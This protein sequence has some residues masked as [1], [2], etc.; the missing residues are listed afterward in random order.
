MGGC[1]I[2]LLRCSPS[3]SPQ[4]GTNLFIGCGDKVLAVPPYQLKSQSSFLTDQ[5]GEYGQ[6]W[7]DIFIALLKDD[8]MP[9]FSQSEITKSGSQS[10][11]GIPLRSW[12]V[13]TCPNSTLAAQMVAPSLPPLDPKEAL[14]P[15]Q[16]LFLGPLFTTIHYC[17]HIVYH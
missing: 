10:A 14:E 1:E 8:L 11:G 7:P 9:Q 15:P 17:L 6:T 4:G 13:P 2:H 3:G 12:K 16:P 5:T